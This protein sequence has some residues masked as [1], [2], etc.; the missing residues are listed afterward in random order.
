MRRG[1]DGLSEVHWLMPEIRGR[2]S[3]RVYFPLPRET[4][5]V[6]EADLDSWSEIIMREESKGLVFRDLRVRGFISF[7]RPEE[8]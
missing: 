5:L 4:N 2:S 3:L 1:R 6:S 7:Q 8:F